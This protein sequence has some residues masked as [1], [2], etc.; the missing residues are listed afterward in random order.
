MEHKFLYGLRRVIHKSVFCLIEPNELFLVEKKNQQV[1]LILHIP[2]DGF[3]HF[4]ITFEQA[5]EAFQEKEINNFSN[6]RFKDCLIQVSSTGDNNVIFEITNNITD[7]SLTFKSVKAALIAFKLIGKCIT[8][9]FFSETYNAVLNETLK[10]LKSLNQKTASAF[11]KK[12]AVDFDISLEIVHTILSR[13]NF[14][15]LKL[16]Q[17]KVFIVLN[18]SVI[19]AVFITHQSTR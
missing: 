3:I 12:I 16:H 10:Y 14:K 19:Q 2:F 8:Q 9:T 7:A 18:A 17:A 13:L 6:D 15:G 4:A 1:N 11:F 5:L